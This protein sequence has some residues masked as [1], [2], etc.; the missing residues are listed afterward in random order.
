[1][2]LYIIP[3]TI[4]AGHFDSYEAGVGQNIAYYDSSQNNDG[5]TR[6]DEYVDTVLDS[7][8]GAIIG[9][10]TAGE[11]L[12]YT[13]N[14]QNPG[15]YTIELRYASGNPNGGGPMQFKL[16]GESVAIRFLSRQQMIGVLGP[17]N[18]NGDST[19][20]RRTNFTRRNKP[21]RV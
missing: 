14:V 20:R 9:W 19:Y 5:D 18:H 11:W 17:P 6:T 4:E 21:R 2:H 12:E 13:V 1:M 7:N 3:G 8:E 15:M 16:D 10:T